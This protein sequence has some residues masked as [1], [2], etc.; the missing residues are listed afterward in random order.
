MRRFGFRFTERDRLVFDL[1]WSEFPD[2][3]AARDDAIRIVGDLMSVA[4]EDVA[5]A[6]DSWR[7][8]V[9]DESGQVVSLVPFTMRSGLQ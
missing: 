6:W 4:Y 9:T 7:I 8:E 2:V 3:V 5:S 1:G